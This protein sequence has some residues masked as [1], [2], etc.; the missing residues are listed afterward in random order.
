MDAEVTG[1]WFCGRPLLTGERVNR[2]P[3][4]RV[5]VHTDCLRHDAVNEGDRPALPQPSPG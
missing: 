1:C 2:A 5:A 3:H 4:A